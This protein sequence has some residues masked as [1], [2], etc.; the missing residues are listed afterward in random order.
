MAHSK[1]KT[2]GWTRPVNRSELIQQLREA[3]HYAAN[4][5]EDFPMFIIGDYEFEFDFSE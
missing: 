1:P 3:L 2:K 4:P 5:H